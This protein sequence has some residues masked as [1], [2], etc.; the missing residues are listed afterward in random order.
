MI[1]VSVQLYKAFTNNNAQC[2]FIHS[3]EEYEF[4][5]TLWKVR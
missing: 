4:G 1:N 2:V 3:W 5:H